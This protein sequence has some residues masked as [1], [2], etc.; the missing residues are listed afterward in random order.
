MSDSA[1]R[2]NSP[3]PVGVQTSLLAGAAPNSSHAILAARHMGIERQESSMFKRNESAPVG[4]S[5]GFSGSNNNSMNN[6]RLCGSMASNVAIFLYN[7]DLEL[8]FKFYS[9]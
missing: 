2:A 6:M 4:N 1:H 3:A 8:N 7:G 9:V 5:K